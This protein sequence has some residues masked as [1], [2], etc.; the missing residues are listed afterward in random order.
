MRRRTGS[1]W[2]RT[3]AAVLT[4]PP[5][6]PS[7]SSSGVAIVWRNETSRTVMP[8]KSW[9]SSRLT[10]SG[11]WEKRK[12]SG[13]AGRSGGAAAP[14]LRDGVQQDAHEARPAG[15]VP[16]AEGEPAAGHQD[17]RELARGTLGVAEVMEREVADDGVERAVG[18]RERLRVAVPEFD[19]RI[20]IAR[21]RDHRVG[22][23]DADRRRSAGGRL[24]GRVA[25]TAGDVEH[26]IPR[27]DACR[28]EQRLDDSGVMPPAKS[29]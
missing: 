29:W 14:A 11:S 27:S 15:K 28:V 7:Q 9:P 20:P 21:E 13:P 6:S 12:N 1:G 2:P 8:S 24:C 23:I 3:T 17:A 5:T 19:V 26:A 25:G 22:D 18:E 10:S 4:V 16:D